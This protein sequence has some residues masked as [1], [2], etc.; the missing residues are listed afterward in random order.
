[1]RTLLSLL[2]ASLFALLPAC[3]KNDPP[4]SERTDCLAFHPSKRLYKTVTTHFAPGTGF[5]PWTTE[6][7]YFFDAQ[8]RVD[9]IWDNKTPSKI[10]YAADGK[11][12]QQITYYSDNPQKISRNAQYV[13]ENG[14]LARIHSTYF[15]LNGNPQNWTTTQFFVWNDQGFIEKT[16]YESGN[17]KRVFTRDACGNIL[18]TQDFYNVNNEEHMLQIA[19]YDSTPDP[20]Y[21]IGLD[22]VFPTAYSVHNPTFDQI[23]HW[24]CADY[25]GSPIYSEYTYDSEGLPLKRTTAYFTVVYFYE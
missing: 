15:D 20:H 6:T 9:S 24:D 23:V 3:K 13:Y 17:D 19:A 16:W 7:R 25:D 1:M 4:Q 5:D 12:D 2:L 10:L 18:K 21:L 8:N 14:R 22:A 11:V